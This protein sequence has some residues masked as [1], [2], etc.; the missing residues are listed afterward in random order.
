MVT[1]KS[2]QGYYW[3]PIVAKMGQSSIISFCFAQKS[4]GQRPNSSARARSRLA[5]LKK[6]P[7]WTGAAMAAAG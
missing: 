1:N 6:E 7:W 5:L 2:Y 3:T 4:L